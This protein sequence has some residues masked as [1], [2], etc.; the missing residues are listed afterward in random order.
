M[1]NRL[2]RVGVVSA[3][4][5]VAAVPAAAP[6]VGLRQDDDH[7]ERLDLGG[8]AGGASSPAST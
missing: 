1:R 4:A 8:P 3:L 5:L 2:R 6:S 7:D